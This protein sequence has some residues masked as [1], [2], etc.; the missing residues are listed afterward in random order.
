MV[1]RGPSSNGQVSSGSESPSLRGSVS[2][3][4]APILPRLRQRCAAF[5]LVF[6]LVLRFTT[7]IGDVWN[8]NL[9]IL[10]ADRR[11]RQANFSTLRERQQWLVSQPPK[12]AFRSSRPCRGVPR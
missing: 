5:H 10:H 2:R 11:P 9:C 4:S 7:W 12:T 6:W 8:G 1:R 3:V